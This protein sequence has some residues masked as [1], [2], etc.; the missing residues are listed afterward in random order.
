MQAWLR[1]EIDDSGKARDLR[2]KQAT[3]L[4]DDYGQG[5]LTAEEAM[6][7]LYE[8]DMRWGDA[9]FGTH[10]SEHKDDTG[11]L[12]AIDAAREEVAARRIATRSNSR[13][14]R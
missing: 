2:V 13:I 11:I 3:Q 14:E 5:K 12:R 4:A 6:N 8:F 7:R 10:A 9:L 1:Q